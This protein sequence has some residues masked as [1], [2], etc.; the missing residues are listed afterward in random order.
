M[1]TTGHALLNPLRENISNQVTFKEIR[2]ISQVGPSL[3][4]IVL[5]S[6]NVQ[7]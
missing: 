2:K 5:C 7:R 6:T 4:S 1:N 3:A